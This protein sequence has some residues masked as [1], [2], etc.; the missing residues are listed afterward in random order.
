MTCIDFNSILYD[1]PQIPMGV[2]HAP[3][4]NNFF[5][6]H[7]LLTTSTIQN[8]RQSLSRRSSNPDLQLSRS[9]LL[10]EFC[11]TDRSRGFTRHRSMPSCRRPQALSRRHE[12]KSFAYYLGQGQRTTRLANL[13]RYRNDSDPS[14]PDALCSSASGDESQ[15]GSVCSRFH[16]DRFMSFAVSLGATSPKKERRQNTYAIRSAGQY[17]RV[18]T[19]H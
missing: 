2:C 13:S 1:E 7:G 19:R 6:D 16:S 18:Y 5:A 12:S 14:G 4:P 17:S 9:V 11:T 10:H 3:G 15:T 8:V